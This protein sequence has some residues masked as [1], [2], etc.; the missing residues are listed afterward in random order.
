MFRTSQPVKRKAARSRRIAARLE[1][2]AELALK[3][4][5]AF[6]AKSDEPPHQGAEE[7]RGERTKDPGRTEGAAK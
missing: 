7:A 2:D 4:I 5:L 6:Q 1:D 3:E